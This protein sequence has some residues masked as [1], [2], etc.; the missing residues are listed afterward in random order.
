MVLAL[1]G[2]ALAPPELKALRKRL[3]T[4]ALGLQDMVGGHAHMRP[5]GFSLGHVVHGGYLGWLLVL[6]QTCCLSHLQLLRAHPRTRARRWPP[7]TRPPLS[8]WPRLG[9]PACGPQLPSLATPRP[10]PQRPPPAPPPHRPLLRLPQLRLAVTCLRQ[11]SLR[12][13]LRRLASRWGCRSLHRCLNMV[14]SAC[15]RPPASQAAWQRVGQGWVQSQVRH[16]VWVWRCR[17]SLLQQGQWGR[18]RSHLRQ[19]GL[20]P[21][22]QAVPA[23]MI[24]QRKRGMWCAVMQAMQAP[25]V[26]AARGAAGRRSLLVA[27]AAA[28]PVVAA[29]TTHRQGAAAPAALGALH[30]R[31][32]HRMGGVRQ[33]RRQGGSASQG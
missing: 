7:P 28:A 21:V 24:H 30:R 3:M 12:L 17:R 18:L 22:P 9:P 23:Q 5:M 10:C 4:R 1:D 27:A 31:R 13:Q 16:R 14:R 25:S 29:R 6:L 15:S 32:C 33:R 26:T 20:R 19:E 8:R 11:P 2:L